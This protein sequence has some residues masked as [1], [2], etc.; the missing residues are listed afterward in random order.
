M[1]LAPQE[2]EASKGS[3]YICMVGNAVGPPAKYI[4]STFNLVKTLKSSLLMEYD[5]VELLFVSPD[6]D[7][8]YTKML[9]VQDGVVLYGKALYDAIAEVPPL[10]LEMTMDVPKTMIDVLY[11]PKYKLAPEPSFSAK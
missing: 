10:Q 7:K 4:F 11:K 5:N 8:E 2:K 9:S 3:K 6:N 1:V